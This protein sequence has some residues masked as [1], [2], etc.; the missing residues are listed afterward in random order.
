[1]KMVQLSGSGNSGKMPSDIELSNGRK[2]RAKI[3]LDPRE[4]LIIIIGA[5]IGFYMYLELG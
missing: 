1:M 3:D 2:P 5:L 4:Y